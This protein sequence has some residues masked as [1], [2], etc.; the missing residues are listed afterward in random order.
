MSQTSDSEAGSSAP[1]FLA[2]PPEPRRGFVKQFLAVVV[3][4]LV[5]LVP[6]AVGLVTF[7]NPL[8]KSV[9]EKQQPTGADADGYYKV[10]SFGALSE[11]PQPVQI[12]ANRK[13]AWNTYP[14]EAIGAI[15]LQRVGQE[16]RAFNAQ[17]PHAGCF[18]DWQSGKKAYHCPCHNSSFAADGKRDPKSPSA[19]DLDDLATKIKDGFVYVKFEK[20]KAGDK[21]KK[22]V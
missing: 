11:T 14:K 20:F 12:I 7:L 8:R 6:L 2:V 5:G 3:G 4:G 13:D 9:R 19:R 21:E 17:C 18:V 1:D 10:A 15:Y 22:V 16:V